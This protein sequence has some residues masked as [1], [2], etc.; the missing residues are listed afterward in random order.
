MEGREVGWG[1][2]GSGEE[3]GLGVEGGCVVGDTEGVGRGWDEEW[4][5]S[6]GVGVG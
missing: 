6:C 5:G 4:G 1:R 3:V 2:R